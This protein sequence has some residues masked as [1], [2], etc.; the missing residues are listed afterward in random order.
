MRTLPLFKV[1]AAMWLIALTPGCATNSVSPREAFFQAHPDLRVKYTK[2]EETSL[3]QLERASTF[4]WWPK[5]RTAQRLRTDFAKYPDL[6]QRLN[7]IESHATNTWN[8]EKEYFAQ[9]A[10]DINLRTDTLFYYSLQEGRM[11]EDGWLVVR[12]GRIYKKYV[13]ATGK[14]PELE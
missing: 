14:Y 5:M 6:V 4:T 9:M 2:L 7:L 3:E 11:T 8:N 13:L 1:L 12:H 10:Q